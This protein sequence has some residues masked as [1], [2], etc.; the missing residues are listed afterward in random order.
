MV[1]PL[2]FRQYDIRGN[3]EEDLTDEVVE[4][5]GKAF[6]TYVQEH[7]SRDVVVGRD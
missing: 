2:I 7:G 1:N 4:L 5:L 3:A 6:G